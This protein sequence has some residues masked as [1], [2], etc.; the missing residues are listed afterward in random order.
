MRIALA[1]CSTLPDWE[2]DDEALRRALRARG[3][4]PVDAVWDDPGVAWSAFEACLIRTTWDYAEKREAFVAWAESTSARTRLFNPAPL[5]RWNTHKSYLR[6]LEARGVPV[7]PT[8]WLRPGDPIDLAR[9]LDERKWRKG[10]L[11]P[12]VGATAR[13]TVRFD[14][15]E[16]HAAERHLRR[17]LARE[18]MMLQPY[19][20]RVEEEGE[21]S[22][23]YIEG[24]LTHAVRK[25][26]V[27]GD[28][29]VQD[30]FGAS[31]SPCTPTAEERAVASR[32]VAAAGDRLLYARVDLLRDPEGRSRLVEFEAVEPLLFF[33]HGAAAAERLAEALL[34]RLR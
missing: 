29:R 30:D 28:Y 12:V 24:E 14:A 8:V 9:V 19:F 33:R 21:T 20:A 4:E 16:P 10:F 23:I 5:V 32:A 3:A 18:E 25:V 22:L 15:R 34:A 31:D 2:R 27:P 1:T 6:D 26:P 13:E 17:M 11:K 7:V